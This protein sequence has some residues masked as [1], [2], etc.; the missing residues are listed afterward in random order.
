MDHAVVVRIVERRQRL[1]HIINS[2]FQLW[3]AIFQKILERLAFY[4]LEHQHH[5]ILQP[6]RVMHGC[7]VGMIET[8]L[9]LDL[10]LE[11]LHL[12]IVRKISDE[13]LHR[14]F[15]F[16]DFVLDLEDLPH[17]PGADNANYA[18]IS[19]SLADMQAHDR[20]PEHTIGQ[21]KITTTRLFGSF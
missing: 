10:A 17:P 12:R 3:T 21:T 9:D 7:D 5:A 11:T 15:P 8:R 16:R 14:L 18:V 13:N 1:A 4:K 2:N 20:T 6:E 19:N